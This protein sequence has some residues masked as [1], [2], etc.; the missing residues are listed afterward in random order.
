MDKT[1]EDCRNTLQILPFQVEKQ[2][3]E[4]VEMPGI[5]HNGILLGAQ[6][7]FESQTG[8]AFQ[9]QRSGWGFLRET[10]DFQLVGCYGSRH[11]K[12]HDANI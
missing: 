10:G 9:I 5:R 6:W 3:R 4:T 11:G 8:H 1:T 7:L 2:S 12:H